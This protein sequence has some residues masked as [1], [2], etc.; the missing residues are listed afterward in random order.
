MLTPVSSRGVSLAGMQ[1]WGGV[2][3]IDLSFLKFL[4]FGE[5]ALSQRSLKFMVMLVVSG[6]KRT[7]HVKYAVL[8]SIK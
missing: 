2:V 1:S 5:S 7:I 8:A 3:G 6:L 4:G